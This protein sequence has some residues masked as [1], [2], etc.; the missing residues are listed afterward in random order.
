MHL[1][2]A[3]YARDIA[4]HLCRINT[5]GRVVVLLIMYN[6]THRQCKEN[7]DVKTVAST[8]QQ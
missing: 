4:L 6:G 3:M 1:L 2:L 8:M 5:D 7:D